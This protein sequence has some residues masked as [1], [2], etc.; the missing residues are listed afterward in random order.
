M[1]ARRRVSQ[2][3]SVCTMLCCQR[4]VQ[5]GAPCLVHQG[6]PIANVLLNKGAA[7]EYILC[8]SITSDE[9]AYVE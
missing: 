6:R 3:C 1:L 5:V 7:T 9:T 8:E 4:V 2:V